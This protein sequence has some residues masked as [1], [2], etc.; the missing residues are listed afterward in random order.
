RAADDL[1][2]A[3]FGKAHQA[4]AHG[5]DTVVGIAGSDGDGHGL[6]CLEELQLDIQTFILEVAALEGEIAWRMACEARHTE[7]DLGVGECR[8]AE[9]CQCSGRTHASEDVSAIELEVHHSRF[10]RP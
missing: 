9:G 7:I 10:S 5:G 3:L 2:R 4:A 8:T 6:C 1:D